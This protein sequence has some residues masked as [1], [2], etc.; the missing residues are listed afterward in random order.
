MEEQ[1]G[2]SRNR[3]SKSVYNSESP[4]NTNELD[5]LCKALGAKPSEVVRRAERALQYESFALAAYRSDEPKG[6]DEIFE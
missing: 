4:L 1:T 6:A 3:L 2:I 5:Q